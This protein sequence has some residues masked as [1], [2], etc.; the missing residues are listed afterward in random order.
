MSDIDALRRLD[1]NLLVSLDVLARASS[2][3][4]AAKRMGV[5]QS[6][7]SHQL[8]RLREL[9]ADPLFITTVR[10]MQ[11]T[12]RLTR[13]VD[14]LRPLL[15]GMVELTSPPQAFDAAKTERVFSI[16]T[17]DL[18]EFVLGARAARLFTREAPHSRLCFVQRLTHLKRDLEEGRVDLAVLPAGVPGVEALTGAVRKRRLGSDG[19]C[20][21]MRPG[22]PAASRRLT[23]NRYLA[24]E[25]LLVS[26]SGGLDGLVE[27]ALSR[28]GR[29]R[30]VALQVSHFSSAPVV[31]AQSDLLA[32]VP[33][34][35]AEAAA[36]H[37]D[38]VRATPPLSLP[39]I[40]AYAFWHERVHDDPGHRWFRERVFGLSQTPV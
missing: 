35:L 11:P 30:H 24:E 18:A 26:P 15:E 38:L 37:I 9:L 21:L 12:P 7:M 23:L 34:Q 13:V 10:P 2:V 16:A 3:T 36:T 40:D 5:T 28:M 31:V 33:T 6:A 8:K 27:A 25:H 19:F 32:T 22:H 20:V 39:Q 17:T 29:S 4:E 14:S 1:L